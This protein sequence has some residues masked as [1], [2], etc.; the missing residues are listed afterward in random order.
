MRFDKI[1]DKFYEGKKEIKPEHPDFMRKVC[2]LVIGRIE[3]GDNLADIT[4]ID[5]QTYPPLAAILQ[6]IDEDNTLS[7][8]RDRAERGRLAVL[9]EKLLQLSETYRSNPTTEL[10]DSFVAMEKLYSSLTKQAGA[11][12]SVKLVF[13][14]VLPSDFWDSGPPPP[15]HPREKK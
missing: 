7:D 6:Y 14:S 10:K 12:E 5:S 13:N 9:K 15:K 4:E 8:L 2:L 11:N 3:K 1:Q